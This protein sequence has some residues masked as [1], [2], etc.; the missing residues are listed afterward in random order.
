MKALAWAPQLAPNGDPRSLECD[1]GS[2]RTWHTLA[3]PTTFSH[4]TERA[5]RRA[6]I[7][8]VIPSR[9]VSSTEPPCGPFGYRRVAKPQQP[10]APIP[11]LGFGFAS[12][13]A[14]DAVANE[15]NKDGRLRFGPTFLNPY[16]SSF[17]DSDGYI[18]ES[19]SRPSSAKVIRS[20]EIEQAPS[21]TPLDTHTAQQLPA[22]DAFTP[23]SWWPYSES[24]RQA[25]VTFRS[26]LYCWTY[27]CLG[28]A[29]DNKEC[30]RV[31]ASHS[32]Y[33]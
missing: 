23:T 10:L 31:S 5:P 8:D 25:R 14:A 30:T 33:F 13:G 29:G 18:V 20:H 7:F 22:S 4:L 9:P 27:T 16:A 21:I 3:T 15:A 2:S 24:I 32:W 12:R 26:L 19:S 6:S 1:G 28:L 17:S 11:H